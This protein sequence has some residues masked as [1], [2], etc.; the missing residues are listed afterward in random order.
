MNFCIVTCCYL[1]F[2]SFDEVKINV[3]KK[4][5][6]LRG[7]LQYYI[8]VSSMQCSGTLHA[9]CNIVVIGR[10]FVLLAETV[11]FCT[12]KQH[13]RLHKVEIKL[14]IASHFALTHSL[15]KSFA[16]TKIVSKINFLRL[17]LALLSFTIIV[18]YAWIHNESIFTICRWENVLTL[19]K[20]YISTFFIE[21]CRIA[22]YIRLK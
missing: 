1:W 12:E 11:C 4:E 3:E 8:K 7:R 6:K 17:F 19:Y 5:A 18:S 14:I 20:V 10:P 22:H 9:K 13:V 21:L 16:R 2:A 15:N